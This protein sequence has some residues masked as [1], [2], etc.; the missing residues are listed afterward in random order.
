MLHVYLSA[1]VMDPNNTE[2]H[3]FLAMVC[4]LI[5]KRCKSDLKGIGTSLVVCGY[6][7]PK[8]KRSIG[9]KD[10]ALAM[11]RNNNKG[12]PDMLIFR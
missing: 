2:K 7:F 9:K 4:Y 11:S 12:G 1:K 8:G 10:N 6:N 5:I 3:E